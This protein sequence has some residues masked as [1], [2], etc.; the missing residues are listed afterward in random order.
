MP[1]LDRA[2]VLAGDATG[3]AIVSVHAKL[4]Y[5]LLPSG[6]CVLAEQQAPFLHL[7]DPQRDGLDPSAP[8]ESDIIPHKAATDLIVMASAH[9]PRGARTTRMVASLTCGKIRRRF[10]VQGDRRCVYRGRGSIAFSE[11]E[12]FDTIP[13]RYERAYGGCDPHVT[14]PD[15]P[16][17]LLDALTPLPGIYPRNAAGRG[18]V[19]AETPAHIDGL[20]LPNVE[21]PRDLL[22]PE[23]LVTGTPEGWWRQPVPWSCD[24]FD[25][26]WYPRSVF[27]GGVPDFLPDDD[28]EV[29]EVR[30]GYLPAGQNGRFREAALAEI[31][32]PR[33]SD[34]ASPGLVVPFLRGDEAIRLQGMTPT[35]HFVV[36]LPGQRPRMEVRIGA[37][38]PIE[39]VPVVNRVLVSTEEMGVYIVWH[40]AYAPPG[41]LPQPDAIEARVDGA[42]VQSLS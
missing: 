42:P 5:R 6:A 11:P 21:N 33:F 23:R 34:A 1:T 18:Y 41:T 40:G 39:L 15:D 29:P 24:W 2:Y 10:L 36:H 4:T 12:P 13:L 25:A 3:R 31:F 19:I 22:T 7:D 9:A 37:R 28:R 30:H 20:L 32:D 14:L 27:L 8:P 35:P 17:T 16:K 38:K 26:A